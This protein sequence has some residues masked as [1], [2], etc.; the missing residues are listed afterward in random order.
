MP[1]GARACADCFP[2]LSGQF[3]QR[4]SFPRVERPQHGFRSPPHEGSINC[5]DRI[6]EGQNRTF[7]MQAFQGFK[8]FTQL[9][10]P[11]PVGLEKKVTAFTRYVPHKQVN[12]Y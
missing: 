12:E 1:L 11:L 2:G 5:C 3:Q 9:S 10:A 4:F 6:K 7:R 8:V